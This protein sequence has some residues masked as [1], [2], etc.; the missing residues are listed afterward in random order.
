MA[1]TLF[2]KI[3]LM[4]TIFTCNTPLEI[5]KM[6][7]MKSTEL[8]MMGRIKYQYRSIFHC[9]RTI[10]QDEGALAFWK[11]NLVML[12]RIL[13]IES[14]NYYTR[15]NLQLKFPNT[16]LHNILISIVSGI[17]ASTLIYPTDIVRQ[18]MNNNT[19]SQ[20]SIWKALK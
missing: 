2:T 3:G 7:L 5:V 8:F 13:P 14:I 9:F 6:R 1:D 11:G 17:T 19:K 12:G 16:Y 4:F 18:L 15:K 20:L 10:R